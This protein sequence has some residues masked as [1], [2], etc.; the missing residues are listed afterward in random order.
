MDQGDFFTRGLEQALLAHYAP[1]NLSIFNTVMGQV[2]QS[3]CIM[4]R[5]APQL[6]WNAA[7]TEH[8]HVT[9]WLQELI[10]KIQDQLFPNRNSWT[11]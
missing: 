8:I 6:C 7:T 3:A 10:M 4:Y 5:S 2:N 11:K 9:F 1:L